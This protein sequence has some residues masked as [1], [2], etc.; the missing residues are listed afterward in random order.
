[1]TA[2]LSHTTRALQALA[3]ATRGNLL[4]LRPAP[5]ADAPAAIGPSLQRLQQLGFRVA[6]T[7]PAHWLVTPTQGILEIHL[8]GAEELADFTRGRACVYSVRAATG[9]P[10]PDS[11]TPDRSTS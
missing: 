5:T 4:A 10:Q 7:Q 9:H 8:Y 3:T 6:E 2:C 11:A 1:M